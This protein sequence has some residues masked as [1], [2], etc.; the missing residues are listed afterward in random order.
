MNLSKWWDAQLCVPTNL[1][2]LSC[3]PIGKHVYYSS[4]NLNSL[5]STIGGPPMTVLEKSNVIL[6]TESIFHAY[7]RKR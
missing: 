3:P 6:N 1:F 4:K 2:F 5:I 7:K